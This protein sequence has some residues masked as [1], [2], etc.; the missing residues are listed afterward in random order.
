MRVLYLTHDL[1]DAATKKRVEMLVAGVATVTLAGFYRTEQA[2]FFVAGCPTLG[3]GRTHNGRFLH[4]LLAVL[5]NVA[6]LRRHKQLFRNCDLIIARNLEMLAL[7]VRGRSF[8][9]PAKPLVYEV[10]D[11]HR[12]LLRQDA[13]GNTMRR[14][15]GWLARRAKLL[16]TSSPAFTREYFERQSQVKLPTL[17]LENKVFMGDA[18]LSLPP[19]P[20]AGPPWRIGWFGALRCRKSFTLLQSFLRAHP[21]RVEVILRGKPSYDQMPDFDREVAATP[22]M[23]FH[24]PYKNPDDLAT[25][26]G[27]VHFC[28]A[29]DMFEEGLNSS[30]LL[31]NR[32][33]E[34]GLYRA[35]PIGLAGVETSNLMKT[36]GIGITLP[37]ASEAAL[38][39]MLE[40]M[41]PERYK[42]LQAATDEVLP[43]QWRASVEECKALVNTLHELTMTP[44]EQP[45]P[46]ESTLPPANGSLP[47]LTIIPCLNE[48]T[49]I[50][51]LVN[52]LQ[53][54]A[55]STPME[56]VIADGGSTDGTIEIIKRLAE[57]H[58]N[59]HYLHNPKR[60]QSAAINLAVVTYGDK[61]D[62]LLR[63][64]AHAHYPQGFC[65]SLK[66][67]A[68]ATNAESVVVSM[69]TIG[70]E[71]FQAAAATAQNSKLGNGGASH[72][73]QASD[74]RFVDH[75]HH[76]LMRIDAFK[77]V[78]GYD[79]S[80]SHN[81]DA[82]LDTRLRKAGFRIWLTG[83]TSMDYFPRSTA[84][85][86]FRQYRG[87]GRGRIRNL[88]KHRDRPKLRQM[89]PVAVVP[90]ILLL[91]VSPFYAIAALPF[92]LWAIICLTY[93]SLL[94]YRTHAQ[95]I[96][97]L[98]GVAA[99]VMHT[100]WSLGFW[101]GLFTSIGVK[102]A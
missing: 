93:G 81:E 40:S 10:L 63:I 22:G 12:L 66:A 62:Y 72:R 35:I 88:L 16:I 78:E 18:P 33:Y 1:A 98:S 13:I 42:T 23:Q 84:S 37:E 39:T 69:N 74:G 85:A 92:F 91:T 51:A 87:Y 80:F 89:L 100:G 97:G 31:P 34:S 32:L 52:Y 44:T 67:E 75:G 4:R 3:L 45:T 70:R 94:D 43:S 57:T 47:L 30:W 46:T 68:L 95:P 61:H 54:E 21:S 96:I 53:Q 50:E 82:E 99:M 41:T 8:T 59:V 29:I 2:P 76:A 58:P 71:G 102:R 7:A 77:A 64:D 65:Q 25:I 49:H 28:W 24:G 101:Q 83:R 60:I 5:G 73:L 90:A 56:I 19:R 26:Y 27:E 86:L 20:V 6:T 11:I 48:A 15:E 79:E 38:A 36:L 9:H 55:A 17:L 14:M